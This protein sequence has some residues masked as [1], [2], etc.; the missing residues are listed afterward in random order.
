MPYL[1]NFDLL[2]WPKVRA[3]ILVGSQAAGCGA[4]WAFRGEPL[5]GMWLA[6]CMVYKAVGEIYRGPPCSHRRQQQRKPSDASLLR[7]QCLA[8]QEAATNYKLPEVATTATAA[9]TTPLL[10]S[11]VLTLLLLLP[12][13]PAIAGVQYRLYWSQS[14][15][16]VVQSRRLGQAES[17]H[18]RT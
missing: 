11:P 4:W 3:D 15:T 16:A 10:L 13:D 17:K 12:S 5:G 14:N 8:V 1:D 6:G 2:Y 7:L 18:L 9:A